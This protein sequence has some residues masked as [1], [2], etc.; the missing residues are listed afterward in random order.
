[1]NWS[2]ENYVKLYLKDTYTWRAWPWQARA[3]IGPLMKAM[4]GAG[5]VEFGSADPAMAVGIMTLMPIEV[6][7]V[8]LAAM[9]GTGTLERI[10]A[11]F[12]M[13]NFLEAQEAR[14]TEAAKKRDQRSRARDIAR[15]QESGF[16]RPIVPSCPDVSQHVPTCPP[17]AQLSSAQLNKHVSEKPLTL[18]LNEQAPTKPDIV[19]RIFAKY[20]L[21]SKS[22]RSK[23]DAKRRKLITL[24]LA[25]FS[26]EDLTRSLD[27][28][29]T[30]AYHHGS[31]ERNTK[32]TSLEL[33]F[34]D[35]AHVEAGIA[36]RPGVSLADAPV[37]KSL[38]PYPENFQ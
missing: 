24:R 31:N 6:V 18:E 12:L 37:K 32:Y 9:I 19:E 14:K 4:N 20:Q 35:T 34:R 28:Y 11:G 17:S 22:P 33:W 16:I 13:P 21:A 26:E 1:M 25:D 10:S 7:E 3:L 5:I 30:S 27:G 15:A 38:T 29:A 36:M 2:D 23:L 8:A